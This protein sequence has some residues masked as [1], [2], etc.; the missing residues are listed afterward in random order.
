MLEYERQLQE[1]GAR[2]IAGIDEAGRGPLAG[3][4]V[5][6][7]VIM[8]L[9]ENDIIE[10]VNDSKKLSAKKRDALY[11]LIVAKALDV[12]VAIIDNETI[13]RDNILNATKS[14]MLQ[15]I[16]GFKNVDRVLIDAVRLDAKVPTLSIIHGDAL[17]YSIAA[18]SI[19]AKVTRDRIMQEYHDKYPQY[20]FA[21]H[22]G[23]GTAEHI[24]LLKEHGPCPIHR[25]TFI[26]HFV[27]V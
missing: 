21:K 18:A 17:S 27:Q 15:C 3:P 10:G 1:S 7:G 12:Q 13:D 22:K 14:G 20:N 26:G 9:G 24:R 23:Y 6:A 8:P 2:Y 25:R 16:N 4:V 11:D 5:V 19:V